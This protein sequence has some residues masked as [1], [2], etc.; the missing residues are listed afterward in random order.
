MDDAAL[1]SKVQGVANAMFTFA[2]T[3]LD[4]MGRPLQTTEPK[5]TIVTYT[6]DAA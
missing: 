3:D 4:K 6:R 2:D 5:G 1:N